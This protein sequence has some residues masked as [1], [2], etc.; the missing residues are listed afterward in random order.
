VV[1]VYLVRI[2][3]RVFSRALVLLIIGTGALKT[4]KHERRSFMYRLTEIRS[5]LCISVKEGK[6][7]PVL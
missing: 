5:C 4:M 3:N 1:K 7:V 6:V 2:T